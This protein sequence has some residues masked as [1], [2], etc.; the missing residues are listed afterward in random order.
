MKKYIL[1][2]VRA[3]SCYRKHSELH[4]AVHMGRASHFSLRSARARVPG[5]GIG[6][7][8]CK[9]GSHS[10]PHR[11]SASG[12]PCLF[13]GILL[14]HTAPHEPVPRNRRERTPHHGP[15]RWTHASGFSLPGHITLSLAHTS[16]VRT[17]F[18]P[19]RL[20]FSPFC[21]V[22]CGSRRA[23][24]GWIRHHR[25]MGSPGARVCAQAP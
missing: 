18:G 12:R 21:R 7:A 5:N 14:S 4:I 9:T 15:V 25:G 19:Q 6:N 13:V 11:A 20:P 17:H 22:R 10:S 2:R 3:L 1:T 16:A 23:A 8:K 24:L